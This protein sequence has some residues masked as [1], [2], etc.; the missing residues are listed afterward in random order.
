M[1]FI[2]FLQ[3]PLHCFRGHK[4]CNLFKKPQAVNVYLNNSLHANHS[5]ITITKKKTPKT[6]SVMMF[7]FHKW[8]CPSFLGSPTSHAD[9]NS[10]NIPASKRV[11]SIFSI[12]QKHHIESCE[13]NDTDSGCSHFP[14]CFPP[15]AAF[16]NHLPFF[17]STPCPSFIPPSPNPASRPRHADMNQQALG[18]EARGQGK[19]LRAQFRHNVIYDA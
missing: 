16:G 9:I 19:A 4:I 12:T 6:M 13:L 2:F 3:R 8:E 15:C 11:L 5:Y 18:V 7:E 14:S 1:I 17:L 10:Q